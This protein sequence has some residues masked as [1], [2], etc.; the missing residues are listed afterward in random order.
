MPPTLHNICG[1]YPTFELHVEILQLI[2]EAL[3][4]LRLI[5]GDM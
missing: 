5:N 3:E 4:D 1:S 2:E